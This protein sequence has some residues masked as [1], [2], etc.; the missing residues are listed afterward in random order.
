MVGVGQA[1]KCPAPIV[2]EWAVQL[3]KRF[4][5]GPFLEL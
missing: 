5:V 3:L 2:N 1:I 4:A